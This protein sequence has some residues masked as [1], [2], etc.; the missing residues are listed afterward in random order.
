M[1]RRYI[2]AGPKDRPSPPPPRDYAGEARIQSNL[3]DG[4][5]SK[6]DYEAALPHYER[7]QGL[8]G[9]QTYIDKIC[10]TMGCIVN[11]KLAEQITHDYLNLIEL[12]DKALS[13]KPTDEIVQTLNTQKA[14]LLYKKGCLAA[15][16]GNYKEAVEDFKQ[17][18]D[19]KSEDQYY[20]AIAKAYN[21]L[22]DFISAEEQALKAG[23]LGSRIIVRA[24]CGIIQGKLEDENTNFSELIDSINGILFEYPTESELLET[25]LAEVW[26][27]QGIKVFSQNQLM[28]A[29]EYF[30]KA[31]EVQVQD[32]HYVA[33]AKA[34]NALGD[35]ASA[36]KASNASL[37][38][39]LIN[40]EAK[41]QKLIA[42]QSRHSIVE[43][44]F[45][46]QDT[47]ELSLKALFQGIM[48]LEDLKY[49]DATGKTI[50]VFI[51]DTRSGKSTT[52]NLLLG[53][54]LTVVESG[55][56]LQK[57]KVL[58]P[59]T[60]DIKGQYPEIG[61][62]TISKTTIPAMY[63]KGTQEL[64]DCPGFG[65][66][67][68]KQQEI[69]NSWFVHKLFTTAASVRVFNLI[70]EEL[71][72]DTNP[73]AFRSYIN[74]VKNLFGAEKLNE[75]QQVLLFTKT[76]KDV[77][78]TDLRKTLMDVIEE[79]FP[80]DEALYE[81]FDKAKV[82]KVDRPSADV[83]VKVNQQYVTQVQEKAKEVSHAAVTTK[84]AVD[85]KTQVYLLE[86]S[87]EFKQML[88]RTLRDKLKHQQDKLNSILK[89]NLSE[90]NAL[91]FK[92]GCSKSVDQIFE[93]EVI[94]F[95]MQQFKTFGDFVDGILGNDLYRAV[96]TAQI[97]SA[98]A[99]VSNKLIQEVEG[100]YANSNTSNISDHIDQIN[101]DAYD[102][103]LLGEI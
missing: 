30:E 68:S 56:G 48:L 83:G 96:L 46:V 2:I 40:E 19:L 64:W 3:G 60:Q 49:C 72:T 8:Y 62:G 1:G 32:K 54:E 82:T 66:N 6:K 74:H 86:N 69:I 17:A 87:G 4:F 73:A 38:L 29:I 18:L 52:L 13:N 94:A 42:M 92:T 12:T 90:A 71:L 45:S 99:E 20:L 7:A 84:V 70:P 44:A 103:E 59:D 51:G 76:D 34:Y 89:M 53:N 65:D 39:N 50:D 47:K 80:G 23:T 28:E 91:E 41:Q 36:I 43:D 26:Y 63:T 10:Q 93:E 21:E 33:I 5:F 55:T 37:E 97:T 9:S 81:F 16:Q 100:Y 27:R 35:F 57:K 79:Q 61:E 102:I 58:L 14:D 98:K 88:F 78:T 31:L 25:L 85:E 11:K 24:K 15:V 95:T 77:S 75:T 22:G 101:S 67:R